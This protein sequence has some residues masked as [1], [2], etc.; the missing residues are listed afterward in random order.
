MRRIFWEPLGSLSSLEE[1]SSAGCVVKRSLRVQGSKLTRGADL[2][3]VDV[4][5]RVAAVMRYAVRDPLGRSGFLGTTLPKPLGEDLCTAM[6]GSV[7]RG[8]S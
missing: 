3:Q 1:V 7:V 8:V 5:T 4:Q 2:P 6:G